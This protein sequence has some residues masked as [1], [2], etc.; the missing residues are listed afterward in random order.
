[1]AEY[2]DLLKEVMAAQSTAVGKFVK[3]R[4]RLVHSLDTCRCVA[5]GDAMDPIMHLAPDVK[6]NELA[7]ISTEIRKKTED[8]YEA[9]I[10]EIKPLSAKDFS[11][12]VDDAKKKVPDWI[13]MLQTHRTKLPA[14]LVEHK[15]LM[16]K[17]EAKYQEVLRS[18]DWDAVRTAM[19]GSKLT[20]KQK[21]QAIEGLAKAEMRVYGVLDAFDEVA[22]RIAELVERSSL[23]RKP[24]RENCRRSAKQA[25]NSCMAGE[26]I[27]AQEDDNAVSSHPMSQ[28]RVSR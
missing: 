2:K 18:V 14:E 28:S 20:D 22:P 6:Y 15:N 3:A 27:I 8:Y 9:V 16:K 21:Q 19:G 11:G 24:S 7:D 12:T 13:A 4:S 5:L 10:E 26:E 1:M 17:F 23:C 25:G